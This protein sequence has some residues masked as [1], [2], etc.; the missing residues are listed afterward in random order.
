MKTNVKVHSPVF[1]HEGAPSTKVPPLLALKRSVMACMLWEDNFYEDGQSIADR[2]TDL[3]KELTQSQIMMV[4][5]DA[6]L[7][8]L[9][10][11]VPLLLIVASF[12]AR[13]K[14]KP[15]KN[16]LDESMADHIA[17]VCTRPDQMTELLSLYW[18]DGRKPIPAQMKKGLAKAFTKFDEY[19]LA[20]YDRDTPIKLRDILFLC[21]AKPKD[22]EQEDLWKRLVS[23]TMK[24][25]DTWETRLT[26]GHDKKESFETLL[27]EGKM[28]RLAILRN[29]RN[30]YDAGISKDL[31]A[32]EMLMKKHRPMLPFQFIAAAKACPQWEDIIDKS[33]ILSLEAKEKL[34]GM[35]L[36]M[37]DVSGSMTSNTISAKSTTTC[38]DAASALAI[39][40]AATC[41]KAEVFSFSNALAFVPLRQGMALRDAIKASQPSGGTYLGVALT[42]LNASI[43][44]NVTVDRIIVITD[45]QTQDTPPKMKIP[46]CYI[47][48]VSTCQNGIKNNGQWTTIS[49]FSEASIDFI[50]ETEMMEGTPLK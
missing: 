3:C 1:T 10:R 36:V 22:K 6:H 24:T 19:Q 29:L 21:H 35:T 16:V 8:G 38:M 32:G 42:R 50:R 47:L 37:V 49:G 18:K 20:K 12:K 23:K 4:A 25:P 15:E 17:A 43:K 26:A 41:E 7:K 14:G 30:M 44:P 34:P 28:G 13:S 45:E 48:N 5:K 31:V 2:I 9:L 40:L 46:R 33:M 27:K 39:L 11:H